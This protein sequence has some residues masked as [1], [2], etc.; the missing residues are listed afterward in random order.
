MSIEEEWPATAAPWKVAGEPGK[1]GVGP[2]RLGLTTRR[3]YEP[4]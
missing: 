3:R 4:Y 2:W 1:G